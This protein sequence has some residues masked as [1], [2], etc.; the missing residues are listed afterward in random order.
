M[1]KELIRKLY[2]VHVQQ[3]SIEILKEHEHDIG[4]E[5]EEFGNVEEILK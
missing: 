5:L 1:T 4:K 2:T 3:N